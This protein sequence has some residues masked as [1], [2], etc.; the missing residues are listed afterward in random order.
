MACHPTVILAIISG[1]DA[2]ARFVDGYTLW[3]IIS[4]FINIAALLTYSD[5]CAWGSARY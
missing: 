4:V 2:A 3:P 5:L 1:R